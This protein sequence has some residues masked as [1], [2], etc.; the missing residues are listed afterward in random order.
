MKTLQ[1]E[2]TREKFF[3]DNKEKYLAFRQAWKTF[4]NEG[5][6][7]KKLYERSQSWGGNYTM[8]DLHSTHHL[9]YVL[10]LGK[11]G[12]KGFLNS[13]DGYEGGYSTAMRGIRNMSYENL[14]LPFGD[15]LTFEMLETLRAELKKIQ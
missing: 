2:N 6:A 9:L 5:H 15:T 13:R 1:I 14:R 3:G 8:S 4:I 11:D 7:K 10:I 12:T